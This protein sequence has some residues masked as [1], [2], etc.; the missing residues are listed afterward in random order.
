MTAEDGRALF[1][2]EIAAFKWQLTAGGI[3]LQLVL[4]QS[5]PFFDGRNY[6]WTSE[7]YDVR[8]L[9]DITVQVVEANTGDEVAYGI[10]IQGSLDGKNWTQIPDNAFEPDLSSV[11]L[12]S[13]NTAL[14]SILL[15]LNFIRLVIYTTSGPPF[16]AT[17]FDCTVI[18]GET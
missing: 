3:G 1:S 7:A 5:T 18:A 9:P 17:E 10:H 16:S 12:G 14:V 15:R 13:G 6:V 11:V 4:T 8:G 2:A